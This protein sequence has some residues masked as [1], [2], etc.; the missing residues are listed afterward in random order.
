M[1]NDKNYTRMLE[2]AS[3]LANLMVVSSTQ[4]QYTSP[5]ITV[6]SFND[7]TEI[8]DVVSKCIKND[9]PKTSVT[10][11]HKLYHDSTNVYPISDEDL[12][13]FFAIIIMQKIIPA[14]AKATNYIP[15][16]L[17]SSDDNTMTEEQS[18]VLE[19]RIKTLTEMF[20]DG[21]YAYNL[22]QSKNENDKTSKS[23]TDI[24]QR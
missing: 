9:N 21:L 24:Q 10:V 8:L 4:Y 5:L 3:T 2:S 11:H 18:I 16:A 1:S 6:R 12:M 22:S 7:A 19:A 23:S 20:N 14:Y 17:Q 15:P 13:R